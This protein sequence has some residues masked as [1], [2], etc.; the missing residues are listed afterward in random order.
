MLFLQIKSINIFA[1]KI[2]MQTKKKFQTGNVLSIASTHMLHDIYS[3]FLAPTFVNRE[4][5][6]DY[7]TIV[8]IRYFS[9]YAKSV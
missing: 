9:T 5:S 6:D 4:I 1:K 8:I 7:V 2:I 3:S